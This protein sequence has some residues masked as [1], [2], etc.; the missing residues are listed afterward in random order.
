[1]GGAG[2]VL[3]QCGKQQAS[4]ARQVQCA[5]KIAARH[6]LPGLCKECARV[7]QCFLV[8]CGKVRAAQLRQALLNVLL[9]IPE[10]PPKFGLLGSTLLRFEGGNFRGRG[11]RIFR[12]R[13]F[14]RLSG[15]FGARQ[16]PCPARRRRLWCWGRG[17]LFGLRRGGRFLNHDILGFRGGGRCRRRRGG[18]RLYVNNRTPPRLLAVRTP[19]NPQQQSAQR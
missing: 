14:I 7:F 4:L 2:H 8:V 13:G 15:R 19:A 10:L 16:A 1:M 9:Q 6:R 12:R 5:R 17:G 18:R 11:F 3:L